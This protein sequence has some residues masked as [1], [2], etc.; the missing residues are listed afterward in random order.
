[1]NTGLDR[2]QNLNLN[3]E[4]QAR[5]DWYAFLARIWYAPPDEAL[6]RV[7]AD[8]PASGDEAAAP[9]DRAWAQLARAARETDLQSAKLEYDL[10]FIGTGKAEVTPYMAHWLPGTTGKDRQLLRLRNLLDEW[11]LARAESAHEPEDHLAALCE[12]M[13]HLILAGGAEENSIS[14]QAELFNTYLA[15]GYR[16]F[17]AAARD[18]Q[19]T[20]F[21]KS[22]ALCTEAFFSIEEQ[23][24]QM[25]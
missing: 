15:P 16:G 25:L 3:P 14:R 10:V 19:Q 12:V 20:H 1:M 23:S 18:S 11:R 24:F 22:V 2:V 7:M 4:A 17:V 21:Y 9:L 5:A 8:A 6:L 13:R